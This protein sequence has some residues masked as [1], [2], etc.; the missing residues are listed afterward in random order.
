M[1]KKQP[2][3]KSVDRAEGNTTLTFQ[4]PADMKMRISELAAEDERSMGNFL[5]N[6]LRKK[7]DEQDRESK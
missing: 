2:S 6:F 4:L 1:K 3:V 7:L 5:V